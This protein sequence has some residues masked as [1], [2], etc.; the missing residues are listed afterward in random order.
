MDAREVP[1]PSDSIGECEVT[2]ASAI[3]GGSSSRPASGAFRVDVRDYG[4]NTAYGFDNAPV[5]QAAVDALAARLAVAHAANPAIRVVG[6]VFVAQAINYYYFNG[7][8]WVDSPYIEIRGEGE[9]TVLSMHGTICHP[10]FIFGLRR[11]VPAGPGVPKLLVPDASYR[12]DLFGKLDSLAASSPGQRWG[13]RSNGDSLIQSQASPISSGGTGRFGTADNWVETN[14]L[15]I[16]LAV[17]GPTTGAMPG[18]IPIAGIGVA[19]KGQLYPFSLYTDGPNSYVVLFCTQATPFGPIIVR[20]FGFSSGL[21]TSV[22]KVA[23]QINLGAAQVSA[24][25]NGDRKSVV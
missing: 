1:G 19:G 24:F 4:A 2:M 10:I 16:E 6:T 20:R 3:G 21:A 14:T 15:T 12:P 17:E 18:N 8:V 7:P 9:G 23:I 22:Q 25:V 11:Q 5:F 13:F